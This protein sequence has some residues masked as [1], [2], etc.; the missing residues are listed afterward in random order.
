MN[1]EKRDM[2]KPSLTVLF[3]TL[4]EEHH[5]GAAISTER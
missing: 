1:A 5:I 4:N 3:I 2:E